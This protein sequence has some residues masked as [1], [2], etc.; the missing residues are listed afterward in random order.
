M[1]TKYLV[2]SG[3]ISFVS[4]TTLLLIFQI[5]FAGAEASI[6]QIANGKWIDQFDKTT[7]DSRWEWVREDS[8]HWSLTERPGFLRITTQE[9]GLF[10]EENTAKN[11][12]LTDPSQEDFQIIT[13]IDFSPTENHQRAG[14]MVYQDDDHY[15]LLTRRYSDLDMIALNL[16]D[17]EILPGWGI[18]ETATTVFLRLV[19]VGDVYAGS[20]SLDGN[21]WTDVEQYQASFTNPKV[22]LVSWNGPST[23]EIPADFDYFE[24]AEPGKTLYVA[25]QAECGDADPCYATIQQAV[26]DA[27]TFDTIKVASGTYTDLHVY[28]RDDFTTTGVVTQVVYLTKSLTI[29][30][31]YDPADWTKPDPVLNM[32]KLDAQ[33]N[34]R[35]MYITGDINPLIEGLNMTGGDAAGLGGDRIE[36]TMSVGGGIYIWKSLARL[37][38]NVIQDNSAESGGGIFV[39]G[40]GWGFPDEPGAIIMGNNI[41]SNTATAGGGGINISASTARVVRNFIRDNQAKM[42][43]GVEAWLSSP[44]LDQNLISNN[45][46]DQTG[47]GIH[48]QWGDPTLVNNVI[49][50]NHVESQFSEIG[51]GLHIEGA[52]LTMS[53]N[54]IARNTS[55]GDQG[56][57]F[58]IVDLLEWGQP[59]INMTNT[60]LADQSVGIFANG[61]STLTVNGVLWYNT[62]VTITTSPTAV[63]SV[64]NEY[65]GDPLFAADGYHLTAGSAALDKELDA[66]VTVDIDGEPRPSGSGFDLGA[67]EFYLYD[68]RVSLDGTGNGSVSSTPDGIACTADPASDCTKSFDLGTTVTLKATANPGSTFLGWGGACSGDGDCVVT[69][70]ENKVVTA[71]FDLIA[72]YL[73]LLSR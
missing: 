4:L 38:N 56:S 10:R 19:K 22:G 1:R 59:T 2:L 60:I 69:M 66:G 67:D 20:Y 12:L 16:E 9:G 5:S 18:T 71:T 61:V 34:G 52:N 30:G 55:S 35:V 8:T 45:T 17:G 40:P 28:P 29:Q 47:G 49:V 50:D 24:F 39:D 3:L 62:P 63:V 31:G 72:I 54:T 7:L 57:G 32:T 53:H 65:S 58:Y 43:G 33:G 51:T 68:L 15:I 73:P 64:N 23:S 25:P 70:T 26:G 21:D 14:L 6:K 11:L 36:G 46:A 41:K 27:N 44:Y 42:G 48:F 13:K 37:E